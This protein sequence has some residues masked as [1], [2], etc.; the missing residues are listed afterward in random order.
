MRIRRFNVRRLRHAAL[1]PL[2]Q[3]S[4]WRMTLP[5]RAGR[6]P[7]FPSI[8]L[9]PGDA[10]RGAIIIG[11]DFLCAG[12]TIREADAPWLAAGVSSDW[13][14]AVSSFDWLRDLRAAGGDAARERG[15]ALIL[16]WIETHGASWRKI[17]WRPD[18]LGA[19]IANWIENGALLTSGAGE[20][21][22]EVLT[23][24]LRQ[25]A[26]HLQRT[27]KYSQCMVH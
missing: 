5:G 3:T 12:K 8:D 10:A 23:I 9:W 2:F 26:V 14:A 16:R 6:A 27:A 4:I 25:Q 19:R 21:F 15:R 20:N 22:L 7:D 17:P 13:I 24:S 18:I 1:Q 11:G